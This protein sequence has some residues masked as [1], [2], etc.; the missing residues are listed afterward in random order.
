LDQDVVVVGGGPAAH[1]AALALGRARKRVLVCDEGRPRNR[2]ARESHT[3]FTRDGTPPLELRR[4][5][6]DQLTR[7]DTVAY[8]RGRVTGIETCARGFRVAFD[9]HDPITTRL[10]LLAVGMVDR[11]ADI[12]GLHELWGDTVIHCPYCH[13]W[14]LR[15]LPWAIYLTG[16]EPFAA[17]AKIRSWSE[18]VIVIVPDDVSLPA[19]VESDL[20]AIG[21]GV[22]RGTI[23]ALHARDGAL[24]SIELRDGRR[25]PRRVLLYVPQQE[26]T[27]LVRALGLALDE[28]GY[29]VTDESARTSMD[30]VF[31]A[32]DLVSP[33]QQ[34]AI[35]AAD[36]LRAAIAMDGALTTP[37]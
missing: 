18:D 21:Y 30:G 19:D 22:E 5:A 37:V 8:R 9:T 31:A 1:N 16:G 26:Q 17:L 34:I 15:D 11:P 14:E 20:V 12:R 32:G 2:V 23:S 33:R 13:G 6:L 27:P 29:V 24:E 7:Y 35:A 3:F 28:A 4:I 36:G 10:V 25:I